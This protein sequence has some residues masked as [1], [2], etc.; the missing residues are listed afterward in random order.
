MTGIAL[1]AKRA[2]MGI[3]INVAGSAVH[4]CALEHAA[5]VTVYAVNACMLTIEMESK[6]RMVH[7]GRLPASGAVTGGALRAKLAIMRIIVNMAGSAVHWRAFEN[8][9][10]VAIHAV[11]F[12][13]LAIK[14]EGKLGVVNRG[15]NPA[16]R[17]MAGGAIGPQLTVVVIVLFVAGETGLRSS[18]QVREVAGIDMA[19]RAFR[20]DVLTAQVERDLVMIKVRTARVN[21]VVT[22]HT[23]S[24]E[25]QEMVGCKSLIDLQVA[26]SA[27]G[28]IVRRSVTFYVTI[29]AGKS[30]AIR[31]GL[32]RGK[33]E[34]S[35][36]VIESRRTPSGR[37]VTGSALISQ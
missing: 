17:E 16:G 6:F 14:M 10:L 7:I 24:T 26:V 36:A 2:V 13:V 3:V 29:F 4:G 27:G 18:F 8:S 34:G 5:L 28:L 20:E 9:I 37:R 25:H 32:V 35:C 1:S 15:G 30:C 22:C 12:G 11:C 31:F 33:Q 23:V 21:T 19:G